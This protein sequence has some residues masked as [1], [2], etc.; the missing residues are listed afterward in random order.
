MIFHTKYNEGR[1]MHFCMGQSNAR[2]ALLLKTID[3]L[4]LAALE[5]R[6]ARPGEK[7]AVSGPEVGPTSAFYRRLPQECTGYLALS[8]PT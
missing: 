3:D 5:A 8:G 2:L 1:L 6:R 7:D 4:L